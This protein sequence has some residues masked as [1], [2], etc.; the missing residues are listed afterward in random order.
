VVFVIVHVKSKI[1][2]K[3]RQL[4]FGFGL[5]SF[6][7]FASPRFCGAQIAFYIAAIMLLLYRQYFVYS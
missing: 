2:T 1:V 4:G 3:L 5:G 7:H 6:R